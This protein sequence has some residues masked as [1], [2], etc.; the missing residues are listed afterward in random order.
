MNASAFLV[1]QIQE[2]GSFLYGIYPRFDNNIDN[3]NIVRHASTLWSLIC[4][5]RLEPDEH[6]AE[7][8]ERSIGFMLDYVIYDSD[9]RAWLYEEKDEEIK[10][11]GCGVAVVA[12]T[13]YMEVFQ[14][15][16]YKEICCA[17]GRGILQMMDPIS[18]KYYHVFHGDFTR[19]EEFRTV[20]YDGEATFALCR[21]YSL[22]GEE[23][24]R[25]HV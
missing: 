20:Y 12:L 13:E 11:G 21:L 1:D 9:G 6:L 16:K 23:I 5:Y 10:L 18:G 25:A 14:N 19:K 3:Y 2:D 15:D 8:I 17:L 7:K 24:G 4:R 22:T